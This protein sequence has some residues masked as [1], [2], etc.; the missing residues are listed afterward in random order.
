MKNVVEECK[1]DG[2][3]SCLLNQQKKSVRTRDGLFGLGKPNHLITINYG[4]D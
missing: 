1:V 3:F 4:S 2:A